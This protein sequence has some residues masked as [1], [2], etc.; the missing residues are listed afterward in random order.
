MKNNVGP[1]DRTL[2]IVLGLAIIVWG[3]MEQ[4]WLGAIGLIP[5]LTGLIGWCPAYCPLKVSTVGKCCGGGKCS[6][7]VK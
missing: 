7:D 1:V 4:N 6:T 2:R 5:L 3:Y